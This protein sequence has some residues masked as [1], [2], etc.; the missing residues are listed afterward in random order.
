MDCH[1]GGLVGRRHNEVHDAI[2]D[3]AFLVWGQVQREPIVCEVTVD[4]TCGEA[5]IVD[6]WIRGVWQPQV[7]AVFDVCVVD[8]DAPSY[9]SRS[10]ETVLCSAEV[11]NKKYTAPCL[12]CHASFTPLCCSADGIH[13]TE[14]NFFLHWLAD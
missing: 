10:P 7:D 4:G 13:D 14:A 1:V 9:R 6:L 11:E 5:L 12:A 3:L 2:C 8:I